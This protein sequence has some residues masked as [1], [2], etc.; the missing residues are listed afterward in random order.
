M[1]DKLKKIIE[2]ARYITEF[3]VTIIFTFFLASTI[4]IK[5][6]MGYFHKLYLIGT[7]ICFCILIINIVYNFIKSDKKIEKIFLNIAIPI[8]ILYLIF[9]IPGHV[10]DETAHFIKAY[11]VSK[12][13]LVTKIDENGE[14]FIT[15]PKI[16]AK[17]NH[18]EIK[19]YNDLINLIN[20]E[21]HYEDTEN[22]I[23]TAQGYNFIM[24]IFPALGFFIARI[25]NI[26]IAYG[27]ILGRL[28]NFIFFLVLAQKAIKKIPFGKLVL[29]IYMLMPMCMQQATSITPDAFINAILFY[30]IS[31]SIYIVFKKEK[32]TKK[33]IIIYILLTALIG[34]LKMVYIL[35]AGVGFLIIKRKDLST[36]QKILIIAGTILFGSIITLANYISSSGY[37]STAE[38]T[39]TYREEFNVDSSEQI[40]LI[41]SNPKH[42]IKAI[43]NDW[44]AMGKHY[45]YMAIGSELGWL[46]IKTSETVITLYLILLIIAAVTE[47]NEEEFNWKEKTWLI[48]ITA[49]VIFL[50]EIALYLDFTPIGAEFIGGIQGRYYIPVYILLLLCLTRKDNYS[51]TKKIENRFLSIAGIL[52]IFVLSEILL[53]FI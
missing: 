52:N 6:Y 38:A 36:K 18:V 19:N 46:E 48:L 25:L 50:V 45:I 31:Y 20:Q 37:T 32:L 27:I 53:Y 1:V 26:G 51:N 3:I 49:G 22:V 2:K 5:N 11:D 42:L 30:Y 24:Y 10:P 40:S 28:F 34:V 7:V 9:M 4:Y 16:L 33:E 8:G 29:S 23:S 35:I 17:Y 41:M 15:V 13:N 44:Y 43:I 21:T 47:K 39:L 14:S 12:G